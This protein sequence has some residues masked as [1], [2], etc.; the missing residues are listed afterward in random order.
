MTERLRLFHYFDKHGQEIKEGMLIRIG[1]DPPERVYTCSTQDMDEDL[2]VN[3]SNLAYLKHHP[4]AEQEFYSL[5]NFSSELI[6][7]VEEAKTV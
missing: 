3:A 4:E 5:C 2:G 7:I 6:E 1:D